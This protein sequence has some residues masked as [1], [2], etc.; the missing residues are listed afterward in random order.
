MKRTAKIISA[1]AV[2][3]AAAGLGILAFSLNSE[4]SVPTVSSVAET[5]APTEPPT[6]FP[7]NPE[8]VYGYVPSPQG[9][10]AKAD[11]YLKKNSD[12]IGWI[13]IDGT[14][15]DYPMVLDPGHIDPNTGYGEEEYEPNSYYLTHG[16]EHEVSKEGAVFI[17]YRD[18]FG[19]SESEQSDNLVIYGHNMGNGTMFGTLHRYRYDYSFYDSYPFIDISSLYKDYQYVI[20]GFMITS[21]YASEGFP[22]WDMEEFETE[23]DFN[24]YVKTIRTGSMV[25]TGVDVKYGDKLLTLSTCYEDYNN[26]RLIIVARKLRSNE[27][28]NDF[29]SIVRSEEYIKKQKEAEEASRAAAEAEKASE[30]AEKTSGT[31]GEQPAS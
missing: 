13:K 19:S 6:M 4:D 16:F 30:E 15:V 7:L 3:A 24:D 1:C 8:E 17:D 29:S 28:K 21:G 23:S 27:T 18:V 12:Y 2:F 26:T 31:S 11:V 9:I 22:Y 10:T 5:Q 14:E 20:F 25:D